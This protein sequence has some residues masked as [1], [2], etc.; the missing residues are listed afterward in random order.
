VAG[1]VDHTGAQTAGQV[2]RREAQVDRDAARLLLGQAIGVS[3]PVRARIRAVFP[4][5]M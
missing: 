3:T 5:S 1:D 4:W 2:E